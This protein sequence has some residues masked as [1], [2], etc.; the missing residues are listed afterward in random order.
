[1]DYQEEMEKQEIK[2]T[3]VK[4]GANALFVFLE[5]RETKELLEKMETMDCQVREG[6]QEVEG[7]LENE[8]KMVLLVYLDPLEH[9]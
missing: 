5:L 3:R 9:L 8:V 2:V 7:Y 6:P 1:M 4:E